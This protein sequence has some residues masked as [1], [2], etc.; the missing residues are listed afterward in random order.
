MTYIKIK[1]FNNGKPIMFG[2]NRIATPYSVSAKATEVLSNADGYKLVTEGSFVSLV[3]SATRFLPRTRV[4]GTYASDVSGT[5]TNALTLTLKA[6]S[7]SF[8]VGD[9]LYPLGGYAE[10]TFAGTFTAADVYTLRINGQNYSVTAPATP[11]A[12]NVAAAFVTANAAALL[13]LGITVAQR[14]STGTLSIFAT[15]SYPI[16][17]MSSTGAVTIAI[18]TSESGYLGDYLSPIGTIASIGNAN[19][20]GERVITLAANAAYV[21][22]ANVPVGVLVDKHLGIYP[23]PLDLTE[24]IIQHIAPIAEADGVYEQNLPY[25]DEQLKRI[26]ATLY[27][28]KRFAKIV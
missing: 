15:D 13:V 3:G 9:V 6:P 11:T 21:V 22:P 1:K 23:E 26:Y 18:N 16:Q 2:L 7:F 8:K 24:E 19:A 10:A 12:A 25:I 27:I 28:N 5:A 17:A 4:K 14:G 20:A